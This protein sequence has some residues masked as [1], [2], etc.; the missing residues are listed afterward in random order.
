MYVQFT[1]PVRRVLVHSCS[2]YTSL[3]MHLSADA[4]NAYGRICLHFCSY[5]CIIDCAKYQIGTLERLHYWKQN[6]MEA[7]ILIVHTRQPVEKN[8]CAR[9]HITCTYEVINDLSNRFFLTHRI[10]H[11]TGPHQ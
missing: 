3:H 9:N 11:R 2:Y 4:Q 1:T 6:N 10:T 7:L 5:S 8:L